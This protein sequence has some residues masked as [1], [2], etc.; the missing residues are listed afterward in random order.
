MSAGNHEFL[1]L[2]AEAQRPRFAGLTAENRSFLVRTHAE[3]W[4]RAHRD[5]LSASQIQVVEEA[6]AFFTPELYANPGATASAEQEA[7]LKQRLACSLGRD[8]TGQAFTLTPPDSP[9]APAPE[10]GVIDRA[11][12]RVLA[13]FSD[14]VMPQ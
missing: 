14:C 2:S 1:G 10:P 8:R 13:W 4:L 5:E 12:D 7:S 6:I 11:I 3:R 9:S